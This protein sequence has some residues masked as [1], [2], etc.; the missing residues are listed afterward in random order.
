[1][2]PEGAPRA[3]VLTHADFEGPGRIAPL[4]IEMGFTLDRRAL[5]RGDPVPDR[6]EPGALLVVMGGSMG[7]GDAECPGYAFLERE[8]LLLKRQVR[9]RAPVLGV[10]LG[11]QLLAH[12]AGA[13]VH[14]MR[15]HQ[16]GQASV[17]YEVGWSEVRFEGRAGTRLL[18]GLPEAAPMLHWHG[19]T[20]DL[21]EGARRLASTAVCREQAFALHD[22]QF[23]LQFHA[24]VGRPEIDDFLRRDA[25]FVLAANGP[26]GVER[27]RDETDRYFDGFRAASDRLLRNLLRA[28]AD[29]AGGSRGQL[30]TP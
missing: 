19:D 13:R 6:L 25:D 12:A 14:P 18:D 26:T 27:L 21:P 8:I 17:P 10:C 16:A 23:G 3:V 11:A 1:M 2:D 4:L 20:F 15:L 7:V 24:E 28:M 22:R 5:H 9:E 30:S 29:A